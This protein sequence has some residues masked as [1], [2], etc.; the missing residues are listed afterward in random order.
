VRWDVGRFPY[1]AH[2]ESPKHGPLCLTVL[3][4]AQTELALLAVEPKTGATRELLRASDPAWVNLPRGA[5]RWLEDGSGFLWL[6]EREAGNALELRAPDGKLIREV[7]PAEHGTREIVGVEPDGSA[8]IVLA[9]REPREQHVWRV[10]LTGAPAQALTANGGYHIALADHGVV[11]VSS[12]LRAGG[13]SWSAIMPDGQRRALPAQNE[14][15]ALVPTTQLEVLALRERTLYAAITR[16]RALAPGRHYP[17]LLKVYAGPGAQSVL[18]SR[19]AYLLDQWYADAGFIVV[20]I[21][22]R[23]SPQRGRSWERAIA[24]DLLTAPL[25]DQVAGLQALFARH[26]ELD[27]TRVGIFGWSFG[28]YMSIMALLLH[29]ELFHAA[30]AGAPVTDWS[31]YDTAYTERYMKLP[32]ENPAGYARTSALHHAAELRGALL[33]MHGASDDN[34]YVANTLSLIDALYRAGKRAEVIVLGSTHMLT[35]PKLA[36]A[37]ERAQVEFFR[38][39][40]GHE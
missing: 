16:P 33:L 13:S 2:V 26:R 36:F 21:D 11:V 23:G 39:K 7:L 25:A 30:V 17:V 3:N 14:R 28:G 34:V 22:G 6:S 9:S 15:P 8:A 31:L 10:P 24:G 37:R 20:R 32:S 5:P 19:D 38:E 4:R 40:L 1:L 18:D 35:D 12:A 29:P 27:R